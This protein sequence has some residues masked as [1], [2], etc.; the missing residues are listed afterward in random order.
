MRNKSRFDLER[1]GSPWNGFT[2]TCAEEEA[3]MHIRAAD[4]SS[5]EAGV[6]EYPP[7]LASFSRDGAPLL[8]LERA[9]RRVFV[10]K[11]YFT[12]I[13]RVDATR[14]APGTKIPMG[15]VLAGPGSDAGLG[16]S[17]KLAEDPDTLFAFLIESH[18]IRCIAHTD[19]FL[20]MG[21][22]LVDGKLASATFIGEHHYYT[23]RR[24]SSRLAFLIAL[25]KTP[26]AGEGLLWVEGLD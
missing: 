12:D 9:A 7:N 23:S 18:L 15:R 25:E 16:A 6:L 10:N 5:R 3:G 20:D 26:S 22:L 24:E 2:S 8:A 21:P 17:L 1:G 14:L 4:F 19:A 11:L 13:E